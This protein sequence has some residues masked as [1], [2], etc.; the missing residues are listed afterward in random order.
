MWRYFCTR[1]LP[2]Y[3][4]G[5]YLTTFKILGP[6]LMFAFGFCNFVAT[7]VLFFFF[8]FPVLQ[9]CLLQFLSAVSVSVVLCPR[10]RACLFVLFFFP[11]FGYLPTYRNFV[12][13]V[14]VVANSLVSRFV[15]VVVVAILSLRFF[16]RRRRHEIL[17]GR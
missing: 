1:Y 4:L 14:V 6:D 11:S 16:R 8:P 3:L 17:F 7:L 9:F 10:V 12:V 2:T 13:A 5:T 15:V